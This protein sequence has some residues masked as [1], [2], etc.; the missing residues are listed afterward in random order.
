MI[1][2]GYSAL[3]AFA[4]VL[5]IG[6]G[7]AVVWI[8][9]RA[10]R[11]RGEESPAHLGFA[12]GATLLGL[13]VASWPLI[14]LVLQSYVPEW[15]GVMCVQGVALIGSNSLGVASHLPGLVGFLEFA[16]PALVFLAGSWLVLHLANRAGSTDAL[17]GRV[18]AA[19]LVF[20]TFAVVDAAAESAYLFIPKKE[21]TPSG[22]CMSTT[23]A[24]FWS[25]AGVAFTRETGDTTMLKV[26]FFLVGAVVVVALTGLRRRLRRGETPGAWLPVAVV[27]A[28]VSL[29]VGLAFLGAVA[30][31]MFLRLPYHQ[32]AYCMGA[33]A[34]ES[35]LGLGFFVVGAYAVGWTGTASWLAGRNG[36]RPALVS[37]GRFSYAA[38]LVMAGARLAVR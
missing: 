9:L 27:A 23:T 12:L 1:L 7:V 14:Y 20:G 35:L 33:K 6:L 16:K 25:M 30:A 4:A 29:P 18:L 8:A 21:I 24:G 19:L 28:I 3:A 5:R 10:L 15:T 13:S 36:I 22:C 26:L 34:P 38:A 37:V 2:N 17:R 11:R 32:C 31:P